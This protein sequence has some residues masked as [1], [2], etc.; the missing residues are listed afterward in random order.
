MTEA[1]HDIFGQRIRRRRLMLGWNQQTLAETLGWQAATI[2]RYERGQYQ[3]NMSFDR[4]RH[5]ADVLQTSIDYLLGRSDDP[6]PIP[7][8]GRS[9]EEPSLDG[10]PP[11]PAL[12]PFQGEGDAD[13]T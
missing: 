1:A 7:H 2:S 3:H 10:T 8:P 9:G 13:S 4:L 11:L 6:G 5:L 12:A